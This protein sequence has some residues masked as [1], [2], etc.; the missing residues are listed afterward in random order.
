MFE[1]LASVCSYVHLI[2]SVFYYEE[3]IDNANLPPSVKPRSSTI[4]YG[5]YFIKGNGSALSYYHRMKHETAFYLVKR[6][7]M[8]IKLAQTE[9][10]SCK[11]PGSAPS[12]EKVPVIGEVV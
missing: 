9:K 12:L 1:L 10:Q 5:T 11:G 3:Y 6:I 2:S 8:R 7:H 4:F